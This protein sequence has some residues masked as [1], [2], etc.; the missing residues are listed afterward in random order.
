MVGSIAI[1]PLNAALADAPGFVPLAMIYHWL[2][3]FLSST[4]FLV[5]AVLGLG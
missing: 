5:L 4:I 3:N 2:G 1:G